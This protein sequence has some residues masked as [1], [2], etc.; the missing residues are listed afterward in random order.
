M[1]GFGKGCYLK[2][3]VVDCFVAS[4]LA[5][6]DLL[7]PRNDKMTFCHYEEEPYV[8]ASGAR[9]STTQPLDTL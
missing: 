5:M 6:T 9:Q 1:D 7:C 8:I 4:L 2:E 3:R